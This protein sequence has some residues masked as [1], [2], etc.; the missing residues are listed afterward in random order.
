[1]NTPRQNGSGPLRRVL[2]DAAL[3]NGFSFKALTVLKDE[4]DPYRHDTPAGHR[5]GQWFAEQVNRFLGPNQTIHLRGMHYL[6]SS[7]NNVR[8]PDRA[9]LYTN[10]DENWEWLSEHAAKAAR[11]LGY[12]P[13]ERIVDERN[14]PPQIFVLETPATPSVDLYSGSS[15]EVPNGPDEDYALPHFLCRD[16]A[17]AQPYRIVFFGEKV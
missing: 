4:N 7:S 14:A 6:V 9:A 15:I 8:R 17:V 5:D 2:E 11:W 13:F 16:F 3:E 12:V 1:M 10:D